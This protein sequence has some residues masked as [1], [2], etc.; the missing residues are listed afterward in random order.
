[1]GLLA[2]LSFRAFGPKNYSYL[3]LEKEESWKAEGING[4]FVPKTYSYLSLEKEV[5]WKGG[6][7]V[8][9]RHCVAYLGLQQNLFV[10]ITGKERKL[11]GGRH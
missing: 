5:S 6:W 7:L 10:L 11:E 1:M 3:S 8:W 9:L 4:T 2:P